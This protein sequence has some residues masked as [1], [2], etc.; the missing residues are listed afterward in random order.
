MPLVDPVYTGIPLGDPTNIAGY[1]GIALEKLV[2][3]AAHWNATGETLTIAT[4]TGTPL[5]GLSQPAQVHI[6]RVASILVWNDKMTREQAANGQVSINSAFTCSLLLSNAYQFCSSNIW[7]LQHHYV[8]ALDMSTCI[9]CLCIWGCSTNEISLAQ[10]TRA[11]P[12]VYLRGGLHAGKWP[13]LMTSTADAPSTLGY[14][15]TN[16]T[17]TRLADSMAQW[18]SIGNPVLICII[19]THWKTTGATSAL[20]CHWNHAGWC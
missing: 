17:G 2:E 18:S 6:G 16:C 15:W 5:E 20:G 11:I 3:T 19:G 9:V 14:H 13:D 10:T 1:T 8:H 7:V 4:Y 12:V